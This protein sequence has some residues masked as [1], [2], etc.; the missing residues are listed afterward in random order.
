MPDWLLNLPGASFIPVWAGILLFSGL[1]MARSRDRTPGARLEIFLMYMIGIGGFAGITNFVM[2]AFFADQVAATIGWPPGSPFQLEVAGANLAIGVIG[3]LG[4]WRRD[5]WLPTLIAKLCFGWTAG[6]THLL[7]L[8][9]NANDAPNNAGPILYLN[10]L[11]PVLGLALYA[12]Y[13]RR[14]PVDPPG[15]VRIAPIAELP[16]AA[17]ERA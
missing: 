17:A 14:R 3:A 5:F 7:D 13:R 4:F 8:L 6:A 11:I 15:F 9:R 2:H 10:F 16:P 12:L 1:H